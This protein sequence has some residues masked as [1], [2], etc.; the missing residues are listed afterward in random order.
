MRAILVSV[1]GTLSDEVGG[2]STGDVEN[3]AVET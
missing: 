3:Q 1:G 2:F